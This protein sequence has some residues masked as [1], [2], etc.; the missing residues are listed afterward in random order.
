MWLRKCSL[1]L[2]LIVLAAS[3][4]LLAGDGDMIFRFGAAYVSPTG[5]F[6]K[7]QTDE[8]PLIGVGVFEADSALGAFAGFEYMFNDLV[9][10]DATILSASHDFED[11]YTETVDGEIVYENFSSEKATVTPLLLSAHFHF[12]RKETL[13][14]YAGPTVGYVMYGDVYHRP[15]KHDFG[16]GAVAG[17]DVPFG[18]GKWMFS[19]A[20]RYIKTTAET[21]A[22]ELVD[23]LDIDV[24]P[25]IVQVGVGVKF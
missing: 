13:D 21:D 24:D 20:V 2:G 1:A 12:L 15:M 18:A 25:V 19:S 7:I 22:A 14:F 6:S 3:T 5:D 11:S 23:Y 9:G 17:I 8:P 4:P 16:Y 10:L